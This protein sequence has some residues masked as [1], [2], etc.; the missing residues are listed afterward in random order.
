MATVRRMKFSSEG[1]EVSSQG[2]GC[3][4]MSAF[5]GLPNPQKDMITV[6]RHAINKGITFLDTAEFY[7]PLT[8]EILVG[9]VKLK[10]EEITIQSSL[11]YVKQLFDQ[12]VY[13]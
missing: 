11:S 10:F 3:M 7:G 9:K 5:Y 2:L 13:D 4:G 1:M 6:I 8:N 12:S